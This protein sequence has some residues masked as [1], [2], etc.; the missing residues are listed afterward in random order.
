[1]KYVITATI[2]GIGPILCGR[3]YP[4]PDHCDSF[5]YQESERGL[6]EQRASEL[7]E[8]FPD[9]VYSVEQRD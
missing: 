4:R 9:N 3:P 2:D 8:R 6:A 1:M 5:N 7:R